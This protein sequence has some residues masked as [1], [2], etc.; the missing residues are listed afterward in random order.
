MEVYYHPEAVNDLKR[1]DRAVQIRVLKAITKVAENPYLRSEG[2][3][4]KPLGHHRN[5]NL[6]GL[7]KI[8]VGDIRV[9]YAIQ[10]TPERMLIVVVAARDAFEVYVKAHQRTSR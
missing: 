10:T 8:K 7:A 3:L 9:V 5:L 6:T 2:G 4:G 1:L